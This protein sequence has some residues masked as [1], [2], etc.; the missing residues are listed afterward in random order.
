ME[1]KSEP[2]YRKG[3]AMEGRSELMDRIPERARVL[4]YL[5][6][7]LAP[8]AS[9]PVGLRLIPDDII[10]YILDFLE[11][12]TVAAV[13]L[14]NRHLQE[15]ATP[16]LYRNITIPRKEDRDVENQKSAAR[17]LRTLSE[18]PSLT[19]LVRHLERAPPQIPLHLLEL[20][21]S[22]HTDLSESH[23]G[24]AEQGSHPNSHL[25][26][27]AVDVM[28]SCV[29]LR[30]LAVAGTVSTLYIM[31][32][33]QWLSF[34]IDSSIKLK[35]FKVCADPDHPLTEALWNH[36]VAGFLDVQLSLDYLDFPFQYLNF[37]FEDKRVEKWAPNLRVLVGRYSAQL[38]ALLSDKRPIETLVL[39]SVSM[40]DIA[41]WRD[42]LKSADTIKEIIYQGPEVVEPFTSFPVLF[43]GMPPS[44]RIFRSEI[45]LDLPAKDCFFEVSLSMFS[46][47]TY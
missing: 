36:F 11:S 24:S 13:T 9:S 19:T 15:L 34:L 28:K 29:N 5:Q 42:Q 17:L 12:T 47:H 40:S 22:E 3:K 26:Q 31:D 33:D 44:L 7:A 14:A 35:R 46:S 25:R 1:V 8:L 39:P 10:I 38:T 20:I 37:T 45:W 43:G 41:L 18:R 16:T 30:S 2:S 21:W 23:R 32:P 6:A 4:T 27:V